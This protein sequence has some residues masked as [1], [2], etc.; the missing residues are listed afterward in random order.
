MQGLPHK[1]DAEQAV[2][3][4]IMLDESALPKLADWIKP[5]DFYAPAHRLI[6]QAMLDSVAQGEPIDT[7]TLGEWFAGKGKLA[8]VE[9]GAYLIELAT[10]TPSAANIENYAGI[11][12]QYATRREI[13]EAGNELAQRG[14]EPGGMDVPQIAA[15]TTLRLSVLTNLRKGD[16]RDAKD[17]GRSWYERLRAKYESPD[18][19]KGM[20]T[21][22]SGL[23]R[24][25]GGFLE[26]DLVVVAG[27]P[28]MGKSAW[29][30]NLETSAA[31]R[32]GAG[33]V[34]DFSLEMTAESR[35]NRAVAACGSIPLGWLRSPTDS[36]DSEHHWAMAS[37]WTK[38]LLGTKLKIDDTMGL[39]FAQIQARC[40]R[41]AMKGKVD[42]VIVDHVNIVGKV[43]RDPVQAMAEI[44]M[45]LK[46]LAKE[47]RC[48]VVALS[49]LN[50]S[51]ESRQNKRPMLADLRESGTIE[52]DA[53]T[54]I[55]L[56]RDDYYAE[57][58]GRQSTAP[59]Q[60][61][62][63]VAKQREGETGTCYG[64]DELGY[65]RIADSD[66]R[67]SFDEPVKPAYNS[68]F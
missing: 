39:T 45:G 42:L 43:G 7:V 5:E 6:Y 28:S 12:K 14:Y 51:V 46:G 32:P 60:V 1:I 29:S 33:Q 65:G 31:M 26:G 30:V 55:F 61:E 49:Q 8:A 35:F 22:W 16:L 54:V 40:R 4:G 20:Q 37:L 62:M 19:N 36:G 64:R 58:E 3:G 53:D 48:P 50:R 27:R 25:V 59:G 68:G 41:A 11:V 9:E 38:N 18:E 63:I 52:Q 21:P 67:P 23:N 15:A 56:Y 17:I 2:L 57:K 10:T 24:M 47:L 66:G 34:L 44:T 13:I